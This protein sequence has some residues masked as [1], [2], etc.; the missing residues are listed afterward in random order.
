MHDRYFQVQQAVDRLCAHYASIGLT[1]PA[2]TPLPQRTIAI[3][4]STAIDESLLE[5]ALAKLGLSPLLLSVNNSTPAVA[6]LCKL[7]HATHL[8]Y[9]SK[10]PDVASE[11]Q[12]LL[13]E[14]GYELE[15]VPEMRFPLWGPDGVQEAKILPFKP[16]LTPSE[17]AERVAVILHSSGSV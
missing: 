9:G 15:I 11:A 13:K 6:H 2:I 7:T 5:I 1:L 4:T 8:I 10:Y 17:E 3:F 12:R 16:A 14:Q